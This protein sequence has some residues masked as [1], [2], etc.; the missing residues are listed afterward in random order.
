MESYFRRSKTP[1]NISQLISAISFC[2]A[3]LVFTSS[4]NIANARQTSPSSIDTKADA[5]V[6]AGRLTEAEPLLFN[7]LQVDRE[8][9]GDNDPK[10]LLSFQRYASLLHK[11]GRS[12]EALPLFLKT[13]R[14]RRK[15]LGLEHPQTLNTMNGFALVLL[16]L[17]QTK[18]AARLFADV[19]RISRKI[20]GNENALTQSSMNNYALILSRQG[21]YDDARKLFAN[22]WRRSETAMGSKH[23]QTISA[24]SN[25]AIAAHQSGD[26]SLAEPLLSKAA[27]LRREVMGESHLST[28]KADLA[29]ALLR[30][31]V[32]RR[33]HLALPPARL[34]LGSI[35]EAHSLT[36]FQPDKTAQMSRRQG[37]ESRAFTHFVNAAWMRGPGLMDIAKNAG[38]ASLADQ[39]QAKLRSE[40]FI[41]LQEAMSNSTSAAMAKTAARRA[42]EAVGPELGQLASRRQLLAE[43]WAKTDRLLTATIGNSSANGKAKRNGLRAHRVALEKEMKAID[44]QLRNEAPN[45]F[46]FIRPSALSLKQAQSLLEKD[47]A[48]LLIV[49]TNFGTH[50]MAISDSGIQWARSDWDRK[51]INTAVKRLLW[52]VGANVEVSPEQNEKWSDEGNGSYPY[53]RKTAFA[54]YN[55]IIAPVA[56]SLKGKKHLFVATNGSLSNMPLGILVAEKPTGAD[57]DPDQLRATKWFADSHALTQIPSLRSLFQLRSARQGPAKKR[58]ANKFIGFGD[59]ILQGQSETRSAGGSIARRRVKT[60]KSDVTLRSVF[61]QGSTRSGYGIADIGAL[62][63]M[64]RLPGTALELEAMREALQASKNSVFTETRASE[65]M[66][67]NTDFSGVNILALATHGLLAGEIDGA[68]EPGLVFTPPPQSSEK[69]DG[70]L[71]ASEITQLKLDADWVIL[72]ACNTAAGDG[73]D[74]ASGLS[75][76]A[77]SFFYAGA[78]NLLA[79]HWP[80]RDDVAAKLTVRTIQ[81]M[82]EQPKLSRAEAFQAAMR[83]IRNDKSADSDSDTWA[84]PNAWAPF[85]LIGDGAN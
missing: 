42:A 55:Q 56:K 81:I 52:D 65:T 59:P 64:A 29:L 62:S 26:D 1:K 2:L 44:T 45:Y 80:V 9:L 73:S 68:R 34:A 47:E 31:R 57:G 10:T 77:R 8:A 71:T 54:L 38:T 7:A 82:K 51:R 78:R 66:F 46:D 13:F 36:G 69:D 3:V 11:M 76:L 19:Y 74:G 28:R 83:E 40:S 75:G 61:R 15:V 25:Y 70:L 32:P 21:Q 50:I 79:S 16:K 43:D 49:P 18:D 5:L 27:R 4:T 53:D 14:A 37:S 22:V 41:A 67:R 39:E 84:H 60:Q 72:S 63:K 33:A 48:A 17:G 58:Q 23:P 35:R 6:T 20:L 85:I 24:L 30:L 12:E